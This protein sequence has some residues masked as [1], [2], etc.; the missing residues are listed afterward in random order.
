VSGP[1]ERV[2][3]HPGAR[4]GADVVSAAKAVGRAAGW[5]NR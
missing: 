3:R 2:T 1:I 5:E 4:Y